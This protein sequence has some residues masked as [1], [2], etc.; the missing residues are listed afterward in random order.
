MIR[1]DKF[2]DDDFIESRYPIELAVVHRNRVKNY[3]MFKI[4]FT[5][6][7][8]ILDHN[9]ALFGEYEYKYLQSLL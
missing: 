9:K 3:L 1:K 8:R 5:K 6:D 4:R 7:K 2:E